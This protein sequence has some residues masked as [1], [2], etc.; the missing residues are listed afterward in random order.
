MM[1]IFIRCAWISLSLWVGG[2]SLFV[3]VVIPTSFR[4]FK[5]EEAGRFL[6]PLFPAVDR[7]ALIWG[8][9]AAGCLSLIFLR[10][11]L[12]IRSLVIEIPVILMFLL[13]LHVTLVLHPQ[14]WEVKRKLGLREFQGTAHGQTLQF[15]F[16]RLHRASVQLHLAILALGLLSLG[17]APR[18]LR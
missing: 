18:F 17:L 11:H 12:E 15:A 7:W 9:V 2:L 3:G 5:K 13:T 6:E 4:T 10:R 16:N 1:S 14:I 8:T